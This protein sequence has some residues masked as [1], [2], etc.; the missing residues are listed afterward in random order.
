M[1]SKLMNSNSVTSIIPCIL[2][3][4]T[5]GTGV[6]LFQELPATVLCLA[7]VNTWRDAWGTVL[8]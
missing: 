1:L 8:Y 4:S 3:C 6:G 5:W 2:V 7:T